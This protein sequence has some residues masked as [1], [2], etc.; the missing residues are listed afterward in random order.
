MLNIRKEKKNFTVIELLIVIGIIALLSALL[1]PAITLVR[2]HAYAL[3]AKSMAQ[4]ICKAVDQ[5]E[6]DYGQMP[7]DA[8]T[9]DKEL[10][11]NQKDYDQFIAILAQ[12]DYGGHSYVDNSDL[13]PRKITYLNVPSNYDKEGYVDP[14]GNRFVIL[15]DAD[16]D[17]KVKVK[18]N[19][20]DKTLYGRVFVYSFGKDGVPADLK[21][22]DPE[23]DGVVSWK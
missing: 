7:I 22:F 9:S 3:K 23:K 19:G 10:Y 8:S 18:I 15:L 20:K 13:N 2:Q 1:F 14:W 11:S 5:F 17:G 16:Y 12:Q 21:K 4:S 6:L